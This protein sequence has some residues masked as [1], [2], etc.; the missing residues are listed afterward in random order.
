MKF[1]GCVLV[2]LASI[3]YAWQT[4]KGAKGACKASL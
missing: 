4:R 1:L 3:E 2:L